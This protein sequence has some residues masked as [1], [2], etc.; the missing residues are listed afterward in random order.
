MFFRSLALLAVVTALAGLA[1]CSAPRL[2]EFAPSCPRVV[3]LADA[4]D[5]SRYR[6]SG[7]R[8]LTDLVLDGRIVSFKGGCKLE[9]VDHV[10]AKLTVDLRLTRG[11]AGSRVS[12]IS[13]FV[14][15]REGNQVLDKQTYNLGINFPENQDQMRLT[16]PEA[17]LIVAV[18]K[19]KSA[20]A[21]DVLIGFQ[22]SA[23]ELAVNRR[24]GL[25]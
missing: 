17:S 14:A 2:T 19:D 20:A 3:I 23:E 18:N 24:R 25:R 1:G 6:A 10:R 15:V 5:L 13:Y 21:Y 4:A 8:D 11:P 22:L 9:G 7:G 12:Q 16:G